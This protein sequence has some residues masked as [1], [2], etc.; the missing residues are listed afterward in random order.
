[1]A[2]NSRS[3]RFDTPATYQIRI[4]GKPSASWSEYMEGMTVDVASEPGNRRVVTLSG[5]LADQSALAG[6]LNYIYDLGLTL[7]SVQRME[8]EGG[9]RPTQKLD[10]LVEK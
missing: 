5:R 7:L 4:E 3:S 10:P 2:S 6:V 1:M 9:A 8:P